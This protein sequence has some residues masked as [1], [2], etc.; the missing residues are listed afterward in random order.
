MPKMKT[1]R[2]SAKRYRL[3]GS[4][5][6]MRRTAWRKHL[7]VHKSTARIRRISDEGGISTADEARVNG[8]L[9]YPKYVR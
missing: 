7:L 9:P 3:T 8:A 6:V 2:A 1:H 4:G 5:K